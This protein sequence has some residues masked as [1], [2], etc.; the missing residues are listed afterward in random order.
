MKTFTKNHFSA[1][2]MFFM[3]LLPMLSGCDPFQQDGITSPDEIAKKG[4]FY[5]A[6]RGTNSLIML[7]YGMQELKRWS[8]NAIAPDT[9][10]LQGITIQRKKCVACIF[11][12]RKIY[13]SGR[14]YR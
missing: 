8:L 13:C 2:A 5:I 4:Y 10:A 14:C 9:V 11:R 6:D 3:L 1:A 7:D 12:K